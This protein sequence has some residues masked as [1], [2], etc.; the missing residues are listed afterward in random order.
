MCH[1]DSQGAMTESST[2]AVDVFQLHVILSGSVL[3]IVAGFGT[4]KIFV[5]VFGH[6]SGHPMSMPFFFLVVA[7]P[8]VCFCFV[9]LMLVSPLTVNEKTIEIRFFW[10]SKNINKDRIDS[11]VWF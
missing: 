8:F 4:C 6:V 5:F 9:V 3:F 2:V 1:S 10:C 7:I 11:V